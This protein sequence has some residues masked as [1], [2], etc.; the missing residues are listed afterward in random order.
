VTSRQAPQPVNATMMAVY[1]LATAGSYFLLGWLARF[2][3]PLGP[4]LYWAL[5]AGL[6]A[7]GMIL[8]IVLRPLVA[9][10]LAPPAELTREA[11]GV[12]AAPA[13]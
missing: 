6:P 4:A 5:T 11:S 1:K 3:E 10:L 12:Q 7:V 8:L 13:A 2:F 9:R